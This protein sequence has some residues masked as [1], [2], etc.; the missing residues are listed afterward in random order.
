L[1]SFAWHVSETSGFNG[2]AATAGVPMGVGG[3]ML[4][5][6]HRMPKQYQFYLFLITARPRPDR[7][8]R[9][10]YCGLLT[11]LMVFLR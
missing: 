8:T 1:E 3:A 4:T 9:T 11:T 10:I 6:L 5:L 2:S 7:E